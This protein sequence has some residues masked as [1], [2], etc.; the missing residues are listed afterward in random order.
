LH[1]VND[2]IRQRAGDLRFGRWYMEQ[3]WHA[4]VQP[5]T[6]KGKVRW[7]DRLLGRG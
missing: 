1:A 7:V 4:P 6:R 5:V 2:R 3:G